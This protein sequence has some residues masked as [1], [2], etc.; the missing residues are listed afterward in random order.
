VLTSEVEFPARSK[1]EF[2]C[3]TYE[4]HQV[5]RSPLIDLDI[6]CIKRFILD[7]MHLVCLGVVK[8]I[9]H[10]LIRGSN[11]CRLSVRLII[12]NLLHLSD[13][14][15]PCSILGPRHVMDH[16]CLCNIHMPGHLRSITHPCPIPGPCHI[17]RWL[18]VYWILSH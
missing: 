6:D 3:S 9:L 14:D 8:R 18:I 4:V 7:Y 13:L 16:A 1:T 5:G 10:F 2:D 11:A 17:N 15:H 12:L